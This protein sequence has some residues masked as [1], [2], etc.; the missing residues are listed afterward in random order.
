MY[1]SLLTAKY[2]TVALN[3]HNKITKN[4]IAAFNYYQTLWKF[5]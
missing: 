5:S 3:L 2:F 1:N 4:I